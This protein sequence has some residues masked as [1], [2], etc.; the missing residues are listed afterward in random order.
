M[1]VVATLAIMYPFTFNYIFLPL[2]LH[3]LA[4]LLQQFSVEAFAGH[5]LA[6]GQEICSP[7]L[8]YLV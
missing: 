7:I 8:I 3:Y 1:W 2:S 5:K 4:Y 6:K